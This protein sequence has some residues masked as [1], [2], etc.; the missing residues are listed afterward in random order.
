MAK[1]DFF[2]R[3]GMFVVNDFL[4]Q[5]LCA[6]IRFQLGS[7]RSN[8]AT[9]QVGTTFVVDEDVRKVR[10]CEIPPATVS[11]L[12]SQILSL[13]PILERH[14]D[15]ALTACQRLEFL[16]YREGDF[17]R[18]HEDTSTNPDAA[19][20]V[21]DRQVS[22]VIFLN[23]EASGSGVDSYGGGSL[24]FYDLMDDPRLKRTG[25][26]LTAAQGLLIA[27]RSNLLHEVA[28]VTRGERYTI[29]SWFC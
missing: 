25:F 11:L 21:K 3:F 20:L 2:A 1:A 24:T 27:F 7:A 4:D 26:P 22:L 8:P 15:L 9:V 10:S 19:R 18:P 13:Q 14:F 16:V 28:R 17:Y 12:R 29:A 23:S 6:R 5:E